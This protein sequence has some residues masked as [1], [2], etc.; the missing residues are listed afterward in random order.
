MNLEKLKQSQPV[1]VQIITNAF[2]RNKVSHAYLFEG[3]KGVGK[4]ETALLFT[5]MYFCLNPIN[6]V[7]ACNECHNCNRIESGNHPDVFMVEPDGNSIKKEQIQQLQKE[8]SFSG[9]ESNKKVYIIKH[10]EKMSTSAANSLLKFLEE[11]N[12]G[13]VAILTTE[14]PN[15]M[16][17]TILSRCQEISF[18]PLSHSKFVNLLKSQGSISEC[19]ARLVAS[20]T[21]NFEEA[22]T[23]YNDERFLASKNLIIS[24]AKEILSNNPLAF[25]NVSNFT[26]HFKERAEVEQGIELLTLFF[27]DMLYAKV[28]KQE[29]V[30]FLDEIQY[31]VAAANHFDP[32]KITSNINAI[33]SAKKRLY[34]NVNAQLVLEQIVLDIQG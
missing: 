7:E 20:L 27:K 5:K 14:E 33:V 15:R 19:D 3:T 29:K 17:N 1:A 13:T 10:A 23:I 21:N 11:P 30:V 31:V 22:I 9:Y 6:G 28:G 18:V 32:T 25:L 12:P 16:L 34:S 24:F 8:F 26:D 2:K 4:S